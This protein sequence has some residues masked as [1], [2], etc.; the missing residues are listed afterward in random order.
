MNGGYHQGELLISNYVSDIKGLKKKVVR[1]AIFGRRM[2]CYLVVLSTGRRTVPPPIF[3][4]CD[5]KKKK[6]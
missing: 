1:S 6:R 4:A 3:G 5:A 2:V